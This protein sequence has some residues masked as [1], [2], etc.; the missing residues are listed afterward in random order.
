VLGERGDQGH[1]D[2]GIGPRQQVAVVG[3]LLGLVHETAQQPITERDHPLAVELE[4][5]DGG[6][7]PR[8]AVQHGHVVDVDVDRHAGGAP[9][10]G[11]PQQQREHAHPDQTQSEEERCPSGANAS[12]ATSIPALAT[13]RPSRCS[14][15]PAGT[16]VALLWQRPQRGSST[17]RTRSLPCGPTSTSGSPVGQPTS[18]VKR[19]SEIPS[20]PSALAPEEGLARGR[21]T[22]QGRVPRA[23]EWASRAG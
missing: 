17:E 2:V 16:T 18:G 22:M 11:P 6:C 9:E 5:H 8:T 19:P 3:P 21:W 4:Q 1:R 14:D 20:V 15:G 23:P 7:Q 13:V 12:T 10:E